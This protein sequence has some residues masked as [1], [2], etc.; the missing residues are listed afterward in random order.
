MLLTY[1]SGLTICVGI[2]LGYYMLSFWGLLV[3]RND[4]TEWPP[5]F[6]SPW[7][8]TSLAEFWAQRWHQAF[9][10]LFVSC[11]SKP[12]ARVFGRLGTVMGAFF[13]SGILHVAG[14]WGMGRGTEFWAVGG[15][16]LMMGVGVILERVWK[17][18]TG[19]RVKG[20]IGRVWTLFWVGFWGIFLVDAWAAK[21]LIGSV[22]FAEKY[23]PMNHIARL[24]SNIVGR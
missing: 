10:D 24:V 19:Y 3:F 18:M 6:D 2:Q 15:Y 4:P 20:W 21:G 5:I 11:G 17:Q 7:L 22:F 23:R 16:F 9:R 14:L 13:I 8:S 12:F 1:L